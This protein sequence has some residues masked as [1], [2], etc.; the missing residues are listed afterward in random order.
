MM[1]DLGGAFVRLKDF[2]ARCKSLSRFSTFQT[3]SALSLEEAAAIEV[4]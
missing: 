2:A 4:T 1:G 3:A